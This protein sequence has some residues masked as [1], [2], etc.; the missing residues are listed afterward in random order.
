MWINYDDDELGHDLPSFWMHLPQLVSQLLTCRHK[1]TIYSTPWLSTRNFILNVYCL[2][3][4]LKEAS[5]IAQA[6]KEDAHMHWLLSR[7]MVRY[8]TVETVLS[9]RWVLRGY[10]G[11]AL[12]V[13]HCTALHCTALHCTALH[14]TA[15][16]C[17][18]L[19]CTYASRVLYTLFVEGEK[20]SVIRTFNYV[21]SASC[22]LSLKLSP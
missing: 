5:G 1:Q 14:C 11:R 8:Q 15:P 12:Q 13:L 17:T 19:H 4:Y 10:L 16:H 7:R 2:V 21:N 6:C 22:A 3:P 18:A 20:L 9:I